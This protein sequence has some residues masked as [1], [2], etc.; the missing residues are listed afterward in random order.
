MIT[1]ML[2]PVDDVTPGDCATRPK[3]SI[4]PMASAVTVTFDPDRTAL[5]AL[6]SKL[7]APSGTR[8][9]MEALTPGGAITES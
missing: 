3:N 1:G 8:L 2:N 6:Q 7:P 5:G 4:D 9:G